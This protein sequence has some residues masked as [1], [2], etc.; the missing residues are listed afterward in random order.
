V[1]SFRLLAMTP[2]VTAWRWATME[3]ALAARP[4]T[5]TCVEP[6][7]AVDPLVAWADWR[8]Y[9]LERRAAVVLEVRP[10]PAALAS[11]ARAAGGVARG[12]FADMKL[13][14]D[15]VE[16]TPVERMVLPATTD[17]GGLRAESRKVPSAGVY[18]YRPDD[19]APRPDGSTASYLLVLWDA[20][21]PTQALQLPLAPRLLDAI[22]RDFAPYRAAFP[23]DSTR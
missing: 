2:P 20:A 19:F 12:D 11:G 18:T 14:R 15:G 6:S 9:A 1:G 10:V 17:A 13:Y 3:R 5:T 16:L 21:D 7:E 23:V 8:D 4:A 22:R